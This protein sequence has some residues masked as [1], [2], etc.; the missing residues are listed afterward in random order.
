MGMTESDAAPFGHLRRIARHD[1]ELPGLLA[2]LGV[3]GGDVAARAEVA[4]A[5]ADDH[6]AVGDAR[7]ARDRQRLTRLQG[8]RGPHRLA[9][10]GVQRDQA[11]VEGRDDRSCPSRR[12]GRG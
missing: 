8:L 2:G 5:V 11:P 7:R 12:R 4:A 9:G 6:L 1:V 10:L 3:I